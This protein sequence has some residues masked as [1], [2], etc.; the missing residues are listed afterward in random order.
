MKRTFRRHL[1]GYKNLKSVI[2][3]LQQH[4]EE[5]AFVD[6]A[7]VKQWKEHLEV[8]VSGYEARDVYNMDETGLFFRALPHRSL[9]VRGEE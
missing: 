3:F 6:L 7:I 1:D 9:V 8:I 4:P 2:T 5:R